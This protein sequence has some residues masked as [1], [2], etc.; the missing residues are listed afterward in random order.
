MES[1]NTNSLVPEEQLNSNVE[2]TLET[3]PSATREPEE[4][5]EHEA[6]DNSVD[7]SD[8]E[9]LLAANEIDLGEDDSEEDLAH[10]T[11]DYSGRNKAELVIMLEALL[12]DNNA[13]G[14]RR[15][16]EAIKI[17]F[18]KLHRADIAALKAEFV[19]KGG[20]EADFKAPESAEE[21][22]L[23]ELISEYKV[24]HQARVKDIEAEKEKNY[25]EKIKILDELKA[26]SEGAEAHNHTYQEFKELQSRWKEIGSV[27]QATVK[28]LWDNYHYLVEKFYD[29]IK[30]NRELRDLDLKKNYEAK[31]LLCEKAEEFMLDPS[32]VASFQKLQKLHEQ[33]REI[34]PVA[35]EFKEVLW[36]RFKDV[37]SKINKR[38]QEFFE[39]LREEQK[40]NL[41]AKVVLCEKAEEL[42]NGTIKSTKEWNAKSKEL[43]ELQKVWKTIGFA[44]KKDNAKIYQRFREA[45]DKFFSI[46]RD[47]YLQLKSVV[48]S[49]LKLKIEICEK[50]EALSTSEDWKKATDELISL[51]K[52]W[53]AIGPVPRKHSDEVWKRFRAACD[54]FFNRKSEHFSGID[55]K[56]EEN[57]A[58]KEE[59]IAEIKAFTPSE[60][61]MASF[62]E[63]KTFQRRWAEIGFVPM[64]EKERIQNEYRETLDAHFHALKGNESERKM[65]KFKSWVD[66]NAG[67]KTDRKLRTERDKLISKIRQLESDISVWENNIGF[68]AKSKNADA[69][70]KEVNNKIRKAKEEITLI[71]DKI[72]LID[73]QLPE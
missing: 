3:A 67:P 65:V 48:D 17:A 2:D 6:A 56:Y 27:P 63:L 61:M 69:M 54:H 73:T 39:S 43:I 16:I 31:L 28:D 32:P 23:K 59:L 49:N 45:C 35:K 9:A 70:I 71:E 11:A 21:V 47:F 18:Y 57:L 24:A 20:L 40:T 44:P 52:E 1:E 55:K 25:Q 26:L 46:K 30:I 38:H 64:K 5:N 15:E 7:F 53:K 72:N 36:E 51:Q 34:G 12:S 22:K 60:D 33:W 29:Y 19:E 4:E 10:P 68:F 14:V 50:A 41:D 62:E 37:T 58:K 13:Q 66:T 42:A 8:E